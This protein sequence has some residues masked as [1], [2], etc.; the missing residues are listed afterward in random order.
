MSK[1]SGVKS[2]GRYVP[3]SPPS[4]AKLE[5]QPVSAAQTAW[6]G[7]TPKRSADRRTRGLNTQVW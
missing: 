3:F 2:S 6:Y 7:R 1:T 5:L 4:R